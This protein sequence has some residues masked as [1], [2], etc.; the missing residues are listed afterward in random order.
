MQTGTGVY[1]EALPPP[2]R[3]MVGGAE[4]SSDQQRLSE[5]QTALNQAQEENRRRYDLEKP[6][7][8]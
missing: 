7:V 3:I 1:V 4:P 8:R 5:V 2:S 6:P